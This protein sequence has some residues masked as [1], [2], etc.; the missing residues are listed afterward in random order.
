MWRLRDLSLTHVDPKGLLLGTYLTRRGA[1]RAR[2]TLAAYLLQ[3]KEA[4][5][6]Q[7]V[8]TRK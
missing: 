2:A 1:Y 8:V 7:L 4:S 5:N 3:H 6:A